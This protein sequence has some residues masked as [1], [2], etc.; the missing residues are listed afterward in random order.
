MLIIYN[1]SRFVQDKKGFIALIA[2]GFFVLAACLTNTVCDEEGLR[3]AG[4]T[5]RKGRDSEVVNTVNDFSAQNQIIVL[6]QDGDYS[7]KSETDGTIE[8]IVGSPS[9]A[10]NEANNQSTLFTK[11][12]IFLIDCSVWIAAIVLWLFSCGWFYRNCKVPDGLDAWKAIEDYREA[13]DRY[14]ARSGLPIMEYPVYGVPSSYKTP[15][16]ARARQSEDAHISNLKKGLFVMWIAFAIAAFCANCNL[17]IGFGKFYLA[18]LGAAV[19][20][21]CGPTYF[22]CF[23]F[24]W[25]LKDVAHGDTP[26]K[27][28]FLWRWPASTPELSSLASV[29]HYNSLAFLT[30]VLL[31]AV[32]IL[33]NVCLLGDGD[34][35]LPMVVVVFSNIV[36]IASFGVLVVMSRLFINEIVSKWEIRA[37]E[38]LENAF[39]GRTENG[40]LPKAAENALESV[41]DKDDLGVFGIDLEHLIIRQ[42]EFLT[43]ADI[44][45]ITLA[46][47]SLAVDVVTLVIALG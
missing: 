43:R 19:T 34:N 41:S 27:L 33:L 22:L 24:I 2:V 13:L 29:A 47:L 25:L 5:I 8:L 32:G 46:A 18:A 36:G 44:L 15:V 31:C 23:S 39:G 7:I 42:R 10:G 28:P 9:S 40:R 35:I 3:K 12:L 21:L 26:N 17:N 38:L 45:S 37:V 30:T 16:V 14:D 6:N 1:I 4:C 20:L 11:R